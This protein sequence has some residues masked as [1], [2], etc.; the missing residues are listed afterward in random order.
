[1][2]DFFRHLLEITIVWSGM[3]L[4]PFDLV[5][6][7][8]LPVLGTFVFYKLF[9]LL[10]RRFLLRTLKVKQEAAKKTVRLIRWIIRIVMWAS[11]VFFIAWYFG[12]E[13][14][15]YLGLF[16]EALKS[17]LFSSGATQISV[18][19]L[20]L[21]FPVIFLAWR[22][23]RRFMK[24]IDTRVVSR[25]VQEKAVRFTIISIARYVILGVLLVL[26]LS[27]IGIDLSSVAV[28]LGV[29]G[30]GIGFGLQSIVANFF[31]GLVIVFERPIKVGDRILVHGLEG[32]VIKIRLRSTVINTLT[33]ETI[34]IPNSQLVEHSIHNYS[35][36]AP[37]II[38]VNA[39]SVAYGADLERVIRVL[40]ETAAGN[41]FLFPGKEV[42]VRVTA[43]GDSGIAM[44]LRTWIRDAH[45]KLAAIAWTN[46]AVWK[47]FRDNGIT[48]PFPQ[49]DVHMKGGPAGIAP[50][51][52]KK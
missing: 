25:V 8:L 51:P 19:T 24:A 50:A 32:D 1:M 41:P 27:V 39:V 38:I 14:P 44:E 52:G 31:S 29:L 15:H 21:V 10:I 26:G 17:P 3:E 18:I 48:I 34:V 12:A 7:I 2:I 28:L 22:L 43:F 23:T 40:E 47:A 30:I 4:K 5:L 9:I 45:Q 20:I 16:W 42:I 35:F 36:D 6:R 13:I 46:L 49:V 11:W 33:N 37:E